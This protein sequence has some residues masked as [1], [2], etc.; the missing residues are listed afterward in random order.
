MRTAAKALCPDCGHTNPRTYSSCAMCGTMLEQPTGYELPR[1]ELVVRPPAW[2][3]PLIFLGLGALLAPVF[4]LTPILQYM[5]W[6][7]G[8]LCHEIGHCAVAWLA[9]CP[10][11][12]AISL[13]G[14][15]MARYSGQQIALAILM[16]GGFGYLTWQYR[17]QKRIAITFGLFTLLYPAFAFT[18]MRDFFFLLGGHIGEL[19]FAGVFF[20]RALTQHR[21]VERALSSMVGWF[22][23]GRNVWLA[24]GLIWSTEV[25]SW[26]A[27][28]G[29]F[30]LTN[31][32]IRLA[33]E[34]MRVDLSVVAFF[35]LLLSLA[36][37]PL[38]FFIAKRR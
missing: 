22:L 4:S 24:G 7:L 19:A 2:K 23:V 9:G 3:E 11:F 1:P 20:W 10:A 32:Y 31:D 6:F 21:P 36:P 5:G 15:A 33:R 12:P 26:Y 18:D 35:M 28:S 25:Q 29:S 34:V 14:H 38:A 8:S 17:H 27:R 37:L 13:A 30:G 16:W